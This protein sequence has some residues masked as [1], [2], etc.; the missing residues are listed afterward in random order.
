MIKNYNKDILDWDFLPEYD[1]MWVDPPW[2]D[3]MVKWFQSKLLKETGVVD[4]S[5]LDA[6]I[7]KL[8]ELAS[9][10]RPLI[11]E[12]SDAGSEHIVSLL[13]SNGHTFYKKF[14]CVQSNNRPFVILVFNSLLDIKTEFK[15]SQ[16]ITETLKSTDCNVILDLFAGI[17]FT[18]NA[19]IK[20]N[21]TY[22]GSEINPKR[23]SKLIKVNI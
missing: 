23:Y 4:D 1:L 18:A 11:V 2:Q 21:K 9:S 16:I 5:T 8:G 10:S 7:N 15:G 19:V 12:Y 3:R 13:V 17:G 22:I 20:A 14:Y 6:I